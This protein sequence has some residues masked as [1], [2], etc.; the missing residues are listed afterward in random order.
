VLL[1]SFPE[2]GTPLVVFVDFNIHLEK[3]YATD[4][5]SPLASFDLKWLITTG[6]HKSGKHLYLVYTRN[7]I[8]DNILV[9]PLH[10]SDHFLTTFNLQLTTFVLVVLF[11]ISREI[12]ASHLSFWWCGYKLSHSVPLKGTYWLQ[13]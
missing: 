8:T 12:D 2:D 7:C 3:L 4:F 10:V 5:I 13:L 1:S 6:T 9:K 11:M